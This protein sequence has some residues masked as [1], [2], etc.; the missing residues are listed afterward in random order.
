ML[1]GVCL[2]GVAWWPIQALGTRGVDAISL[3]L[4]A[5]G[6][7]AVALLRS[8]FRCLPAV[9]HWRGTLIAIAIGGAVWNLGFIA[10]MAEGDAGRR[11]LLCYLSP[12]WAILGGRVFL[13]EVVDFRRWLSVLFALG[14][15]CIVLGS[16]GLETGHLAWPDLVAIAAGLG[17]AGTNLLF[18]HAAE[19][20]LCC[21]NGAMFLGSALAAGVLLFAAGGG[22]GAGAPPEAWLL[23]A[24]LGAAWVLLADGLV[25]YG[26]SR[27]PAAR[28]SVL[29]LIELPLTIVSAALIAGEGI[30]GPE[31]GGGL[32]I[33]GAAF[34]E[35]IRNDAPV[36]AVAAAPVRRAP[37]LSPA[38]PGR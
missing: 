3:T 2:W 5:N 23:A 34:N 35:L 8:V 15:A 4:L 14:G 33:L 17:Q 30:T 24:F 37:R 13:G 10:A 36:A 9:R 18:R 27:L 28:S 31:L 20:P 32:L 26:V 38:A 6:T 22:S 16:S 1:A 19:V 11:A 25:Q 29:L 21:K 12:G 7:A